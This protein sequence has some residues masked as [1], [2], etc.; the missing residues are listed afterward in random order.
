MTLRSTRRVI[1]YLQARHSPPRGSFWLMCV[2]SSYFRF[3]RKHVLVYFH[4]R[5]YISSHL[6]S[7]EFD[8]QTVCLT[9]SFC[10]SLSVPLTRLVNFVF[11]RRAFVCLHVRLVSTLPL[12]LGTSPLWC[13][14]MS[15]T[16]SCTLKESSSLLFLN[17]FWKN[18]R[19]IPKVFLPPLRETEMYN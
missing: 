13:P 1:W 5:G 14:C 9:Y 17:K 6:S 12:V 8:R 18:L 10:L 4:R 19:H 7:S 11:L 2:L 16:R 3:P 15:R